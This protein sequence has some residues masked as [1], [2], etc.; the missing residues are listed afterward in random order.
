MNIW[1]ETIPAKELSPSLDGTPG[2]FEKTFDFQS[3]LDTNGLNY[4]SK[5]MGEIVTGC[6][7]HKTKRSNPKKLPARS[8][9]FTSITTSFLKMNHQKVAAL[10]HEVNLFY[11]VIFNWNS[12][13][14][15]SLMTCWHYLT[16]D[17][18]TSKFSVRL[19]S[20]KSLRHDQA[21]QNHHSTDRTILTSWK[22]SHDSITSHIGS[23]Q[24]F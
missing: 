3:K 22:W 18:R 7:E 12:I 8:R 23:P 14:I 15:G 17:R 11:F 9:S 1:L 20:N 2:L 13:F 16:C 19:M 10:L 4:E 24:K 6:I 5:V 21:H